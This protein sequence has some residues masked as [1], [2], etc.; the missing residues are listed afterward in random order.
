MRV[1]VVGGAGTLGRHVVAA[2]ERGGHE[3]R[4][5]GRSSRS[6]PVD[7]TTGSGLDG[8]LEGCDSVVDASNAAGS[9]RARAVLVDGGRRLLE[10]EQRAGVRHHV[11]A[12]IVGIEEVPVS[13]YRVKLEQEELVE[14]GPVPWTIVRS[15]QFHDLLGTVLAAAGRWH[16]L[17]VASAR[18]Q[19]V[20]VE[21]VAEEV[22]EV[23]LGQ[24]RH[25]RVTVAGPEV[26]DLG[27]LA[28]IWQSVTGARA[29]VELP[30]PLPGRL[31]RA[32][33]DGGL[34]CR[35][36]DVRGS[37]TFPDWLARTTGSSSG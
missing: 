7:L 14:A 25:G 2:L 18:F 36:P 8:G 30:V 20:D 31:G 21:E 28:Q 16:V 3:A 35:A 17:P 1:A 23:A 22:A 4:V 5:L 13:Y 15:T 12:S 9:R 19:P 37:R 24:P 6:H 29:T 32:L 27:S 10:A 26:H 33:R 11:C 34:T